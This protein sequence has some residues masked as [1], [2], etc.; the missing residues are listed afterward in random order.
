MYFGYSTQSILP[1]GNPD[2]EPAV[3]AMS[4]EGELLW[5][6][7]LYEETTANSSPDQ[8]VDGLAL[9]YTYNRLVVLARCHGNN[10]INLWRGHEVAARPDASA[11]Q[12][13]F[14]GTNGNIHI[15]WLGKFEIGDGQLYAA[16]Y[17]AEYN[18][19]TGGLGAPHPDPNLDGWPNPNGGWPNVNTTRCD[20]LDV[21]LDGQ[22]AIACAGRR[23]ITTAGAYQKMAKFEDG[24]SAWNSFLRVY[25]EDFSTLIYSGLIVGD[26]NPADGTGGGN[27]RIKGVA[28]VNG[29]VV[30][31]GWHDADEE[32]VAKGAPVPTTAVPA[33]GAELPDG[34]SALL[35]HFELD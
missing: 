6:N 34:E 12:N 9:D 19:T 17:V 28:L 5:W 10:V 31:A 20:G 29:G 26:F 7:R 24:S 25:P 16:T 2:F 11:F 1:G 13:Q 4:A 22:V 27:T 15:G 33:W 35:G 14:T 18:D 8:Y 3:V 32:G 21:D 30:G 23:T